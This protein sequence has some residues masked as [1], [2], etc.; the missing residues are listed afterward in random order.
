[1]KDITK[2]HILSTTIFKDWEFLVTTSDDW[3][4]W[5]NTRNIISYL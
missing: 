5:Y 2:V 3:K 4:L 1:M